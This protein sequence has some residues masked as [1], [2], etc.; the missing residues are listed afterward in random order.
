MKQLDRQLVQ[1]LRNQYGVATKGQLLHAGVGTAS[2]AGGWVA[3]HRGV[4]RSVFFAETPEQRLMAALLAAGPDAVASHESAS[5]LWGL[6]PAPP[7][8]PTLTVPLARHPRVAGAHVYRSTNFAHLNVR[9]HRNF[10][11]TDPLWALVDLA[12]VVPRDR[13]AAAVDKALSSKLVTVGAI[14]AEL[15]RRAGHGRRGAQPLRDLLA[16]RGMT[17]GPEPS[18]LEA[19]ALALL[20]RWKIPVLGREVHAGPDG[21]YRVDIALSPRVMMEVDGFA[22]HSSPEAK[23]YDEMRRNQLRLGG[24]FL[25]VYTWRDVRFAGARVGREALAALD[26]FDGGGGR[27][28]VNLS[29]LRTSSV[30][31]VPVAGTVDGASRR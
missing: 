22:Y 24:I 30:G 3:V 27:P 21:R 25:L 10:P 31:K 7:E 13:L 14:E 19:E 15:E 8:R 16:E 23:A 26:R 28:P 5:W 12:G 11:C 9:H 4:Y 17:G 18:A 29:Q 20:R 1:L 2:K 6:Q